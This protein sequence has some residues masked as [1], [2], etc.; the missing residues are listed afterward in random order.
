MPLLEEQATYR[1]ADGDD[2]QGP[3][4]HPHRNR[5]GDLF[6]LFSKERKRRLSLSN[7]IRR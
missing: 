4:R 5:R 7:W 3:R 2:R 1:Q 6:V